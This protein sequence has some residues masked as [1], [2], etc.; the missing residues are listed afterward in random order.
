MAK[1][2]KQL[3]TAIVPLN[4]EGIAVGTAQSYLEESIGTLDQESARAGHYLLVRAGTL[5]IVI[6][7]VLFIGELWRRATFRYVRAL[8]TESTSRALTVGGTRP[9]EFRTPKPI[10]HTRFSAQSRNCL[11]DWIRVRLGRRRRR[12]RR[13]AAHGRTRRKLEFGG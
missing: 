1:R 8:R 9:A 2:F 3:S 4:E 5:G 7:V 11:T 10:T 12:Q 6:L 13:Y